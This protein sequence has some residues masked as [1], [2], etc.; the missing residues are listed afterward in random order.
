MNA[1][2]E[3]DTSYIHSVFPSGYISRVEKH[4]SG[5]YHLVINVQ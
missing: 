2:N 3:W 4:I 5:T 1:M